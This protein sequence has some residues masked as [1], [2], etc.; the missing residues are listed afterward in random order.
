M[1]R[2]GPGNLVPSGGP[3]P[4]DHRT[5][6]PPLRLT[7]GAAPLRRPGRGSNSLYSMGQPARAFCTGAHT[8]MVMVVTAPSR[9]APPARHRPGLPI[10]SPGSVAATAPRR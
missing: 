8:S 10:G 6:L 9:P 4:T 3:L 1:L 7:A 5:R 2:G